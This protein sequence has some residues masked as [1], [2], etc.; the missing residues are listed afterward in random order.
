MSKL[1]CPNCGYRLS[2]DGNFVILVA[3]TAKVV[4]VGD[5]DYKPAALL[6]EEGHWLRCDSCD[7]TFEGFA[8][9]E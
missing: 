1:K 5:T 6:E 9:D 3:E 7:T 8:R 4:P 2:D